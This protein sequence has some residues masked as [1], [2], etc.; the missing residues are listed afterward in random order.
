MFHYSIRAVIALILL[1]I[2]PMRQATACQWYTITV[3]D[4]VSAPEVTWSLLDQDGVTW[5]S[6]GASFEG[7]I[8]LPD[9]CY[10][11][12]MFDSGANG[13]QDVDFFIED[14]IGEFV[15]DTFLP[16]GPHG[17]D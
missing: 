11:L 1:T 3:P 10:T 17:S 4:G 15:W 9:G 12:L 16:D 14:W 6:G 13:W 7:D 5:L 8:C 2:V